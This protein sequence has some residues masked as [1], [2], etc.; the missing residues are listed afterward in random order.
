MIDG[1]NCFDQPVKKDLKIYDNVGKITID[2]EDGYTIGY[3]LDYPYFIEN[4]KLI[5]IVLNKQL[6][7]DADP[8]GAQLFNFSGNLTHIQFQI[9]QHFL[10]LKKKKKP[11]QFFHHK[12]AWKHCYL[13]CFNRIST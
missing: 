1:Q 6:E 3:L 12:E 11:F 4:Y 9:Q 2:Q 13:I 10:L 8:K 5:A 7:N